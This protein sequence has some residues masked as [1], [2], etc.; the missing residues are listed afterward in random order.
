M[1]RSY[2][3]TVPRAR[4]PE[5]LQEQPFP[6]KEALRRR[7][8]LTCVEQWRPTF[9]VATLRPVTTGAWVP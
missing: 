3:V 4:P 6:T 5:T 1:I 7:Q 9:P 2:G 8:V